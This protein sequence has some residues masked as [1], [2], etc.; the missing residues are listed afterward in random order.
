MSFGRNI[1]NYIGNYKEVMTEIETLK[2]TIDDEILPEL[3]RLRQLAQ[4]F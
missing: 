4:T 1:K 2:A 3:Q